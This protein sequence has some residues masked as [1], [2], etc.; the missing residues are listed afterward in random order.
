MCE[1]STNAYAIRDRKEAAAQA[2]QE[3]AT[4]TD[5]D[6]LEAVSPLGKGAA[7]VG[8]VGKAAGRVVEG[9]S[10]D[11]PGQHVRDTLAGKKKP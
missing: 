11:D 6:T 3:T 2:H 9:L 10:G 1:F 4:P 7:V 5:F 8:E